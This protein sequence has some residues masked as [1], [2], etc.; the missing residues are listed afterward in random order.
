MAP[1]YRPQQPWTCT[2]N[3]ST[4]APDRHSQAVRIV[5]RFDACHVNEEQQES[6]KVAKN[7]TAVSALV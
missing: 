7:P 4:L 3:D 2:S 5:V 1:P 6:G